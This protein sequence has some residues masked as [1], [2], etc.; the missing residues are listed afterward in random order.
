MKIKP[1]MTWIEKSLFKYIKQTLEKARPEQ[2]IEFY[3]KNLIFKNEQFFKDLQAK[4]NLP[5]DI[6]KIHQKIC[7]LIGA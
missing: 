4:Y 7:N 3:V 6:L 5:N 1:T 2:V